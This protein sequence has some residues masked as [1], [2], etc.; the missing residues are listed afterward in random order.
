MAG[1]ILGILGFLLLFIFDYLS[2]IHKRKSKYVFIVLGILS[3]SIGSVLV[4]R[5]DMGFSL[6]TSLRIF[7]GAMMILFLILLMYSVVI[8]VGKNTYQ[9]DD[10]PVLVTSGTYAISRHPG[11]LW[12]FG[13]YLS[14]GFLLGHTGLLLASILFTLT[15]I[16]YVYLQERFIFGHIFHGYHTYQQTTPFI[17]P[18]TKSLKAFIYSKKMEEKR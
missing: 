12:L 15:N 18:T 2:M 6:P 8:E 13:F 3:I 16:F 14:L 7:F 11:V 4:A 1:Y 17:I 10:K 5:E 9:Y